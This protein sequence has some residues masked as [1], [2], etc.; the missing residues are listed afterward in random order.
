MQCFLSM[1]L[2]SYEDEM[3]P[4]NDN[5]SPF[6]GKHTYNDTIYLDIVQQG[7]NAD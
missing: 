2:Q 3:D 4:E 6:D 1:T 7:L 5:N